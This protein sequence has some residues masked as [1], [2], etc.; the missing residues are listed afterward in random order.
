MFLSFI[1]VIQNAGTK[2]CQHRGPLVREKACIETGTRATS[3]L[4][5]MSLRM[6]PLANNSSYERASNNKDS[7][8][9]KD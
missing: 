4:F 7:L 1:S 5:S 2:R 6:L 9:V 3:P 8:Y